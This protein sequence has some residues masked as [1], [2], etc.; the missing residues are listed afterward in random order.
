[1][2]S[3][4]GDEAVEELGEELW[5]FGEEGFVFGWGEGDVDGRVG[6]GSEDG[7]WFEKD[8]GAWS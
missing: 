5:E 8:R 3:A 1:M 2:E 7:R 6:S 4:E